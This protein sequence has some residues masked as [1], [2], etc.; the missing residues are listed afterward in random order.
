MTDKEYIKVL[1]GRQ[2]TDLKRIER[3]KAEVETQVNAKMD[4]GRLYNKSQA[5]NEKLR[6]VVDTSRQFMLEVSHA[7]ESGPSWYTRGES[8]LRK[9]VYMW[10]E[11]MRK[12]LAALEVD[13]D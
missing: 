3:L 1:E 12:A 4:L 13:D 11:R 9:Q 10:I 5:D 7:M 8:G 6:A 2:E